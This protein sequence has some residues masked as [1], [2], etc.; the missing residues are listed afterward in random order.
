MKTKYEQIVDINNIASLNSTENIP[1]IISFGKQENL[2]PAS[3]DKRKVLL[4]AID[5]Q[6]DFM[7]GIGSLPVQGSK[8]DVERLTRW[9]YSNTDKITQIICS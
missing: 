6:N 1:E 3:Q 7:E 4:L 8:G 2:T 5:V 9:I